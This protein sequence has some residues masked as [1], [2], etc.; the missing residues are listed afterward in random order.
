[1]AGVISLLWVLAPSAPPWPGS[2]VPRGTGAPSDL[3][4]RAGRQAGPWPRAAAELQAPPGLGPPGGHRPH[5]QEAYCR[6]SR[7]SLWKTGL[8]RTTPT[9]SIRHRPFISTPCGSS[10]FPLGLTTASVHLD[11]CASTSTYRSVEFSSLGKGLGLLA[12]LN[13]PS[14]PGELQRFFGLH[15][16]IGLPPVKDALPP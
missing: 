9:A 4:R 14:P 5:G 2:G 6:P 1:M 12:N 13:V 16:P 10:R 3:L 15:R 8:S 7:P 11:G